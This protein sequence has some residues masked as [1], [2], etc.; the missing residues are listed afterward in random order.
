MRVLLLALAAAL[1]AV[2]T[3]VYVRQ[4]RDDLTPGWSRSHATGLA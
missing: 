2:A 1:M 3:L 4:G